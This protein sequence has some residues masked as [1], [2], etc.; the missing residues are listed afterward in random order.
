MTKATLRSG[1]RSVRIAVLVLVA[2]LFSAW[3]VIFG[4]PLTDALEDWAID[5]RFSLRGELAPP[6]NLLILAFDT[7]AVER[8]GWSPPP[9]D[10]IAAVVEAALDGG[11]ASVSVDML[12]V[13]PGTAD[14]QLSAALAKSPNVFLATA[15]R[16][17]EPGPISP[18]LRSALDRSAFSI[19]VN[20]PPTS[21]SVRLLA[22]T[23]TLIADGRLAHVNLV[24]S[25]DGV[26]RRVPLHVR[27]DNQTFLP[28]LGLEVARA[29]IGLGRGEVILRPGHS[30]TL[31]SQTIPTNRQGAI[32]IN[33]YGAAGLIPTTGVL[34][35]LDAKTPDDVFSG[36]NVFIGVTDD[37]FSDTFATPFSSRTPGVEIMAT[38]AGNLASGEILQRS[39]AAKGVTILAAI[40]LAL[41]IGLAANAASLSVSVATALVTWGAAAALIHISFAH[42]NVVV[43][44]VS[45]GFALVLATAFGT[46]SVFSRSQR[47]AES[48]AR[49]RRNLARYVSPLLADELAATK[50][51]DFDRREQAATVLF[52]DLAGFTA[53]SQ[54]RSSDEVAGL[55]HRLHRFYE[56]KAER[57][58]G[59]IIS[60]E[61]DGAMIVF[62]L[63]SPAPDDPVRALSC[64]RDLVE[65]I[66]AT[67]EFASDG[68]EFHLRVSGHHG[69]VSAAVVGGDRHAHV[70]LSG[71]TVNVAARLQDVAK[72]KGAGFVISDDLRRAALAGGAGESE[73]TGI[74]LG[75]VK[76][77]GR[78]RA[79]NVWSV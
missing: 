69:P 37:S 30:V 63:P 61:G 57:H 29:E 66:G 54:S 64:G 38:V 78:E 14:A 27:V 55:V 76:L 65:G 19:V 2:T 7:P 35:I 9:R 50:T 67:A 47:D 71:D 22:P 52:A 79:V 4:D 77:R 24:R 48:F 72:A 28:S 16:R 70:T 32:P 39:Y 26:A 34:D 74:D 46:H 42:A 21:D 41:A 59:V 6:D 51:P 56:S 53:F 68:L 13:E 11:A 36:K 33:H 1:R 45:L 20:A 12:F 73:T 60:F 17:G 15:T 8:L 43:D 49:E 10:A 3:R 44:V 23:D 62:G 75:I 18:G 5:L 58:D 31:G 40:T 25:F